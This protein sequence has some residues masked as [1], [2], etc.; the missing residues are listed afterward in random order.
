MLFSASRSQSSAV[1]DGSKDP[2]LVDVELTPSEWKK[3][4]NRREAFR[5]HLEK[6]HAEKELISA[7]ATMYR[8][9]DKPK[10]PL[11]WLLDY[12][13]RDQREHIRRA[14][15][16]AEEYKRELNRVEKER[17]DAINKVNRLSDEVRGL[18]HQ[19]KE[20]REG[21]NRRV[22]GVYGEEGG[23]SLPISPKVR[24]A[25]AAAETKEEKE[26]EKKSKKEK[27]EKKEK[28]K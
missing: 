7:F 23:N 16:T 19:L 20:M 17:D 21:Q 5:E 4:S 22:V 1:K 25:S 11:Q 3:R 28:K 9:N 24:D 14:E 10:D 27:K 18:Q 12:F 8:M 13:E 2:T 6:T 26:K 15:E